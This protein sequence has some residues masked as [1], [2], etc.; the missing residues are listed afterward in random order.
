MGLHRIFVV[1]QGNPSVQPIYNLI[2][3]A[4]QQLVDLGEL[5]TNSNDA[6]MQAELAQTTN[7]LKRALNDAAKKETIIEDLQQEIEALK[8][9]LEPPAPPAE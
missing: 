5:L 6:Q 8:K 7:L 4:Q 3:M 1:Y 9:K 2:K